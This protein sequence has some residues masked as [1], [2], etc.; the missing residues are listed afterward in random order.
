M[1]RSP[2]FTNRTLIGLAA[3]ILIPLL[4]VFIAN[5]GSNLFVPPEPRPPGVQYPRSYRQD[6][7][8]Y[9]TIQRPDGT[10]RDL[11]INPVGLNAVKYNHV[12]PANSVMVVEGYYAVENADGSYVTDSNGHYV[13]GEPMPFIHVREKRTDWSSA[14]FTSDARSGGWNFGSFDTKTGADYDESLN[15]CF[16]CHNTAPQDFTYSYPLIA[17]YARTDETIYSFCRTTGRTACE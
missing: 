1:N 14:D 5:S 12:L 2:I 3:V 17:E 16:L 9:S 10:I 8:L 4:V 6:F 13:K 15:I 11:Y 7:T